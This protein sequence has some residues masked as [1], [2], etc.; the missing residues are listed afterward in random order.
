MEW[1]KTYQI[2]K[3]QTR[4]SF[5]QISFL[6]HI[7]ATKTFEWFLFLF[8]WLLSKAFSRKSADRVTA[9]VSRPGREM[10]ILVETFP[11][12]LKWVRGGAVG[13]HSSRR[14]KRA[15]RSQTTVVGIYYTNTWLQ[16]FMFEMLKPVI[17]IG[18]CSLSFTHLF[19]LCPTL[20]FCN[21][22]CRQCSF[23]LAFIP[24]DY[25]H[26]VLGSQRRQITFD[27]SL[28]LCGTLTQTKISQ[29]HSSWLTTRL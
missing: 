6:L 10:D 20:C 8:L 11:S 29:Q 21:I 5:C 13:Q 26:G 2:A 27:Q 12:C 24:I 4:P 19:Y 15:I 17:T 1:L 22:C 18:A 16:A 23:P 3:R 7:T 25:N 14:D 28:S 9:S